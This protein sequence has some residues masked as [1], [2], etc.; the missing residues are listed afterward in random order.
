MIN[1]LENGHKKFITNNKIHKNDLYIKK[2]KNKILI[3]FFDDYA[4]LFIFSAMK[5]YI[6][7][8]YNAN[9]EYFSFNKWQNVQTSLKKHTI[10]NLHHIKF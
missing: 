1:F 8:K 7:K 5:K 2:N 6:Q 4:V 3:D 10:E 9:F